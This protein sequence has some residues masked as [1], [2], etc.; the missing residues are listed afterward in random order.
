MESATNNSLAGRTVILALCYL[1]RMK[2]VIDTVKH[3]IE[4]TTALFG[5]GYNAATGLLGETLQHF[6]DVK[7]LTKEKAAA[8]TNDVIALAPVIEQT[9]YRTKEINIGVS[10]PPRIIIHFEKFAEISQERVEEILNEH[11]EKKLLKV[12]VQ[13]L[14]AADAFQQKLT[15]G[16]FTFNEINISLSVPPEVQVKF[17]NSQTA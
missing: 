3:V 7:D 15:M 1:C 5:E 11:A 13:T 10:V 14:I 6:Y 12:I 4:D 2:K 17:V 8:L 9:G 16:N